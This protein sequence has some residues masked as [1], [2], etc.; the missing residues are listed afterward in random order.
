MRTKDLLLAKALITLVLGFLLGYAMGVSIRAEAA[1]GRALTEKE[2]LADFDKY[3]EHLVG[4][5]APVPVYVI[6]GVFFVVVGAV[7]YEG[8][9]YGLAKVIVRARGSEGDA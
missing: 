6:V 2:Y 9:A 5:D 7:V 1:R 4:G 3:K 8:L